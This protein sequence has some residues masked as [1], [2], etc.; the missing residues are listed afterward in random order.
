[1]AKPTSSAPKKRKIKGQLEPTRRSTRETSNKKINY[2]F[3]NYDKELNAAERAFEGKSASMGYLEPNLDENLMTCEEYCERKGLK[4]GLKIE[5]DFEGWVEEKTCK[6]LNFAP[7][8]EEHWQ[9]MGVSG[10]REAVGRMGK[11]S[12]AKE[13]SRKCL[14]TNPNMYFYRHCKPGEEPKWGPWEEDEIQLFM[15]TATKYGVGD[16]W[17]LFSSYIPGR[18]GYSCNQAYRSIMLPRGLL[19]DDHYLLTDSG[20]TVIRKKRTGLKKGY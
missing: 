20:K 4:K 15:E 17:G 6:E 7:T 14:H 8:Q 13:H 2:N 9:R 10:P 3:D 19:L 12:N 16:N 1:V 11:S 18:V 5:R